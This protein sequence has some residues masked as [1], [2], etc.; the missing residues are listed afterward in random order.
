MIFIFY[1]NFLIGMFDM[2]GK[3]LPLCVKKG[4][5]VVLPEYGGTAIE[6]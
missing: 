6:L 3:L 4:D 1:T 2:N 5:T